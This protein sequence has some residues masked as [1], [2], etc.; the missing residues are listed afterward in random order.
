M[1][2]SPFSIYAPDST[3]V[4]RSVLGYAN[5]GSRI[6]CD[7]D[8]EEKHDYKESRYPLTSESIV[9]YCIDVGHHLEDDNS[10]FT[11]EYVKPD[12]G[13][14]LSTYR[15]AGEHI[16]GMVLYMPIKVRQLVITKPEGG[17]FNV[18]FSYNGRVEDSRDFSVVEGL[19]SPSEQEFWEEEN[20]INPNPSKGIFG[21]SRLEDST[22]PPKKKPKPI[23]FFCPMYNEC[24]PDY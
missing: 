22:K 23:A 17:K 1:T 21:L 5:N 13:T 9:Y 19:Q 18:R 4:L 16:N 15:N 14:V 11:F 24:T 8:A 3:V 10:P 12:D 2:S 6:N 20:G 7:F